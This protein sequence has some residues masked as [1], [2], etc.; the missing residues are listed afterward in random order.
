[1]GLTPGY[2]RT[3]AGISKEESDERAAN[4]ELHVVRLR[5]DDQYPMFNDLVYGKT[6]QNRP[7]GQRGGHEGVYLDPILIKSD[8]HPT[9]H[10]ANVV[11]DHF[12]EITHVIRGTEWMS[13]TP[14]H[15]ALYNA[16][17]WK[18]PQFGHVPLLVDMNGQKL[19]KRNAD[20]DISFF[21][22]QQGIFP[23]TLSNF[24]ALLGWSHT[25]KSDVFSLKELE[26]N[27]TKGNTVVAF[28]KLWFLQKAHAKRYAAEGGPQ[29]EAITQQVVNA[30]L[31]RFTPENL[32]PL[33]K[34]RP[35]NKYVASLLQEGARSYTTAEEFVTQNETFFTQAISRP[36]YTSAA[37]AAKYPS[38]EPAIPISTLHT[39]AAVLTMIPEEHWTAEIHRSNIASYIF[40]DTSVSTPDGDASIA[41]TEQGAR[42]EL[43]HYLRWALSGGA[44]GI[45]IPNTMEIL[46]RDETV[47]RLQ[48]AKEATKPLLPQKQ[49]PNKKRP[50]STEGELQSKAW[51]GSLAGL[52]T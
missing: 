28:E 37:A 22:D 50:A 41:K 33:L 27:L 34:G 10:L 19:S 44:P 23:E 6:G 45:G 1:M 47:R 4:G 7:V 40:S 51:M 46:G 2:D 43:F 11:D 8:G 3:C 21:K 25:R 16:F 35:L 49:M 9:Y 15:M 39:A 31:R 29:F 48:D 13:S 18:P 17:E 14:M 5:V 30:V 20:I 24:A 32:S 38:S 36:A 26:E 12:M 52:S 42:K